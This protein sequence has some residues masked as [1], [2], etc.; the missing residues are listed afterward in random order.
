MVT[1]AITRQGLSE[2]LCSTL[3]EIVYHQSDYLER[4]RER[5]G[6]EALPE[7]TAL[8]AYQTM[9]SSPSKKLFDGYNA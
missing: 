3:Y 9:N 4:E 8:C 1:V 7:R 6:P 2:R 5:I